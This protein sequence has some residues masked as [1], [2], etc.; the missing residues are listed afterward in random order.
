VR[1]FFR[2]FVS[3]STRFPVRYA[4]LTLRIRLV[5]LASFLLFSLGGWARSP[6]DLASKLW[7]ALWIAPPG[8]P[9]HEY[10]VYHF[11]HTVTLPAIPGRLLVHVSGDNRYQLFANGQLVSW[12][13][14]RGDL[15]HW[16]YET[17]DLAPYLHP[18]ANLLAAVVWN[19]GDHRAIA[20]I[21]NRTGFLL[22]ADLPENDIL[23]TGPAWKSFADPAYAWQPIPGEQIP[24]YF[25]AP[26]S[27]HFDAHIY[28]WGWQQPEFNDAAWPPAEP[29]GPGAPRAASDTPDAWMLVPSR[30]PLEE[31]KPERFAAVRQSSGV[32]PPGGF[33][34]LRTPL[35]IPPQ[36]RATLLLDQS[37]L[38]TAY[39]ELEV[40]GGNGA[41][42][43][44]HYA[45]A[46]Y[47]TVHPATKTNRNEVAGKQFLGYFDTYVAD[48][49]P[50]RLYRPLFWRTFRY[51]E[52]TVATA[53]E[54]LTI[55]DIRNVFTA[56]PF[57][58][59][60]TLSVATGD[61]PEAQNQE[62][63]RILDTG[64]RTAR[65]CAHETYMDCPYWEQLQYMGDA[66]IQMLVSLYSS[67]DSRLMRNGI[68]LLNSSRTAEGAT[69]SRAPSSLQQYIPPFSLFWIGAVHDYWMYTED[70][71][72]VKDMLPGVRAILAFYASHQTATG[73][74]GKMPWW[75]FVDWAKQWTGGVP[76]AESD[77]SHAAALD[78]Q[79]L[80][81]YRWAAD[82]EKALGLRPLST[83]Y[84][85]AAT[86]L[87][88]R[89]VSTDWDASRGLF[90]DQPSHATF[91]Q[92][93]NTLAVL[94]H[95]VPQDQARAVVEKM[96]TDP[97]LTQSTIYFLAYTNA[98]LREVGLG[99]RYLSALAPWRDM[100]AQGLTTWAEWNGPDTRSDCHAWGASPNFELFRTLAGIDSAA[101]GFRR[102]RIAP[103]LGALTHLSASV[104]HPRGEIRVD[105]RQSSSG[106]VAIVSLPAGISGDF[107][108]AGKTTPLHAGPN[109]LTL[110][111]G[112]GS[113]APGARS[114]AVPPQTSR[115]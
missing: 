26:P 81:A 13:P 41:L 46:L 90:A 75:N 79:L 74:L 37:Y 64:W 94:A 59:K 44:L 29:L 43:T 55:E 16:R 35:V 42:I 97:T 40:S 21:S 77:G 14:A 57:A 107:V 68:E 73:S 96:F 50:H 23:N 4:D 66:R 105:L 32:V 88:Q 82:L 34:A 84:E 80:L 71:A 112:A 36:T 99:D 114:L 72:F 33:P 3:L 7:P 113:I 89:I 86:Q 10:G 19:D 48:G 87:A 109:R 8:T 100:L 65:L 92:Q 111:P 22:Q 61:H 58:R 47:N 76:P 106:L 93:V 62:L 2:P 30:I 95:L 18:G 31:Q 110:A 17:V 115:P 85:T 27:E 104:P 60:A 83:V 1:P 24:G 102:V 53:G 103:S 12:G 45:E 54:P 78:L 6:G 63:Q 15:L 51:V 39:P 52:L 11:R 20:Q 98:A 101:P 5:L 56:Y 67:G 91:S 69:F 70:Q 28:P 49:A 38:T 9:P 108:W 25:A